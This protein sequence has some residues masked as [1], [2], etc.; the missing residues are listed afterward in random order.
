MRTERLA[1]TPAQLYPLRLAWRAVERVLERLDLGAVSLKLTPDDPS[2]GW[3]FEDGTVG[4]AEDFRGRWHLGNAAGLVRL[5]LETERAHIVIPRL[6][7]LIRRQHVHDLDERPD[8]EGDGL[9]PEVEVDIDLTE[10]LALEGDL[11]RTAPPRVR[12]EKPHRLQS[13]PRARRAIGR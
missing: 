3:T 8:L 2:Q 7:A 9:G 6:A 11:L 1:R 4:L 5:D 13:M 12:L 10:I